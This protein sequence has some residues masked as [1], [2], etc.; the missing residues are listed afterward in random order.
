MLWAKVASILGYYCC[1]AP[2]V[3]DCCALPWINRSRYL[4]TRHWHSLVWSCR[5]PLSRFPRFISRGPR[6]S[7]PWSLLV[8][9]SRLSRHDP[10]LK[11]ESH[12]SIAPRLA[13]GY[14]NGRID[15]ELLVIGQ[16][17]YSFL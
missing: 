8:A 15:P 10:D 17:G 4:R 13:V 2:N 11:F 1:H 14:V 5:D 9:V 12:L 16:L 7:P 6:L 3:F